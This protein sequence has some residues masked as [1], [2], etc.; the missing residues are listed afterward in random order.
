M[1]EDVAGFLPPILG[2]I[3]QRDVE[4]RRRYCEYTNWIAK[5][6]ATNERWRPEAFAERLQ[7][8]SELVSQDNSIER[9]V[10][11]GVAIHN[12]RMLIIGKTLAP[13]F[14]IKDQQVQ[15]WLGILGWESPKHHEFPSDE[16]R[17]TF[18]ED[19]L[20]AAADFRRTLR[21]RIYTGVTHWSSEL[22]V[23]TITPDDILGPDP[24]QP[25]TEDPGALPELVAGPPEPI[26]DVP[27]DDPGQSL[28]PDEIQAA[29][30]II[31]E[32]CWH[33]GGL[34]RIGKS[35]RG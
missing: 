25:P 22:N 14:G 29:E 13:L 11:C 23:P 32:Q 28:P 20:Q 26:Y 1:T 9:A 19:L 4:L 12:D 16:I 34:S 33:H 30:A 31:Q 10:V 21:Y 35:S 5:W 24:D 8:I 15:R 7:E 6:K 18:G 2:A 27:P 17:E 3:L